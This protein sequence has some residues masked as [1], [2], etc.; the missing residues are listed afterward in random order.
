MNYARV[1]RGPWRLKALIDETGHPIA[2]RLIFVRPKRYSL[3]SLWA[4][5]NSPVANAFAF[6]HLGK[7]DNVVSVIKKIPMPRVSSL[8]ALDSAVT[9]YLDAAV[10]NDEPAELEHRLSRIDAEVFRLYDLPVDLERLL[11]A[12]FSGWSRVGVPFEQTRFLPNEL[13]GKLHY[14]DFV[15]YEADWSKTNR[16]RGKLIDKDIAG[17]LSVAERSELD[18]LQAYADYHL[19]RVAPRPTNV[20][21]QLEDL[22]LAKSTASKRGE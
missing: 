9:D 5:L 13:E 7:R 19:D 21:K 14:A 17:T 3:K 16:R 2:S 18:G 6:S 22:V 11:H 20:L 8:D 4:F 1:S 15:D 12:L 10:R